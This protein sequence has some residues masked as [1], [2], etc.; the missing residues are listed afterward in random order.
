MRA[1]GICECQH[2]RFEFEGLPLFRAFCHCKICQ[3][4]NQADFAD[5]IVVRSKDITVREMERI[6][7]KSYRQPPILSR[8]RCVK[9]NG[10][11][12]ETMR[13][14]VLPRLTILPYQTLS[15]AT[16]VPDPQF[17]MFYHRRVK[18][19]CDD[20]PK[21]SNYLQSQLRFSSALLAGL[22]RNKTSH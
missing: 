19:V 16:G 17:H 22:L 1:K 5:I 18:E 7:F 2:V 13:I 12:I 10:V 9:C 3:E 15:R 14:P 21:S 4:F 6:K 20:L 8:G 11:A